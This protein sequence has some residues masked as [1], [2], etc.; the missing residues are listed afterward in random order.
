ME[1]DR[2]E[3]VEVELRIT[4]CS[5]GV[6]PPKALI[7]T[8]QQRMQGLED[9]FCF[10]ETPCTPTSLPTTSEGAKYEGYGRVEGSAV[11]DLLSICLGQTETTAG[12]KLLRPRQLRA[13]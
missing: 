12:S 3:L 1:L 6:S 7:F 9:N 2:A 11:G 4:T 13:L 8:S 5:L 10:P